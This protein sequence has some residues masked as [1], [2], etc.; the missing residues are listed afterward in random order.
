METIIMVIDILGFIFF[1]KE[2]I[3]DPSKP[4]FLLNQLP[5]AHRVLASEGTFRFT[6]QDISLIPAVPRVGTEEI[7]LCRVPASHIHASS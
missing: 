7:N 5:S 6:V 3:N 4:L 1:K 2:C